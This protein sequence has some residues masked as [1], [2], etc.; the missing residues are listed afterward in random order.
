MLAR[1]WR[2]FRTLINVGKNGTA[3]TSLENNLVLPQRLNRVKTQPS[4]SFLGIYEGE[5][6]HTLTQN[7]ECM[8]F[9]VSICT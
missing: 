5:I 1:T 8:C 4:N 2:K 3:A 9:C 6:N 7:H